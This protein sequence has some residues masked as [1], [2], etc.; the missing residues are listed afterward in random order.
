MKKP[1]VPPGVRPYRATGPRQDCDSRTS[2]SAEAS[3]ARTGKE[4]GHE[5][6]RD[7]RATAVPKHQ[8]LKWVGRLP[9]SR[10]VTKDPRPC[11]WT[12]VLLY[13]SCVVAPRPLPPEHFAQQPPPQT[14][15]AEPWVAGLVE[16][17]S[18]PPDGRSP[19]RY[20][21]LVAPNYRPLGCPRLFHQSYQARSNRP[22][23][24]PKA[25]GPHWW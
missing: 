5:V 15:Q 4:E 3:D 6:L 21:G 7:A 8:T 9:T 13:S 2:R 1:G 17:L 12:T 23:G 11:C 22:K 16:C 25:S 20:D 14:E 18:Q 19:H 10:A 24:V